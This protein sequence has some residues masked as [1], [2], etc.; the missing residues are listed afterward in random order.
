MDLVLDRPA[1]RMCEKGIVE[2][3]QHLYQGMWPAALRPSYRAYP[4]VASGYLLCLQPHVCATTELSIVV[5]CGH[6]IASVLTHAE[7]STCRNSTDMNYSVRGET[8]LEP[9]YM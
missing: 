9:C 7:H 3:A 1:S 2:L 4:S 5:T 6:P 8:L